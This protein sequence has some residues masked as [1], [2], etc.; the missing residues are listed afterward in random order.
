[1]NQ[2]DLIEEA[3]KLD[4]RERASMAGRLLESLDDLSA[5]EVERLWLDEAQR[6]DAAVQNGK[7]A[8]V[9]AQQVIAE[10]KAMLG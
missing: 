6:R 2:L 4:A 7:L 8:S 10:L 1:M 3:L 9:P 5:D